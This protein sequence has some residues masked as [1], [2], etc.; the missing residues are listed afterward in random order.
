METTN[1]THS[2]YDTRVYNRLMIPLKGRD[3]YS[4]VPVPDSYIFSENFVNNREMLVRV[5]L[6][7]SERSAGEVKKWGGSSRCYVTIGIS[8]KK[9]HK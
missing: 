3:G 8:Q 7:K 1:G 9:L 4:G 2:L 6:H 5:E